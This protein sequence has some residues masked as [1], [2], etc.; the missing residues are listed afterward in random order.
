MKGVHT[1]VNNEMKKNQGSS[2]STDDKNQKRGFVNWFRNVFL[3]HYIKPTISIIILLLIGVYLLK[4]IGT[5]V[6]PDF[7][8]VFG[9]ID[10]LREEDMEEIKA[11]ITDEVGDANGDG[12]IFINFEIYT[13]TLDT[14]DDYGKQ[15]LQALDM[16]FMADPEKIL[17]I[18]DEEVHLRYEP[19]FFERLSDYGIELEDEYFYLVNDLPV[20]KRLL[21]VDTPYYMGLKGWRV[22]QKDNP[23][24]IHTYDLAVRIMKR[25]INEE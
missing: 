25:L 6:K 15:N 1:M 17:F 24:Y 8:I 14:A 18:L 23:D 13:A 7:T 22:D 21:V 10:I 11:I 3:Y 12:E 16:A 4:D 9:G 5:S 2:K 19:D 20:F